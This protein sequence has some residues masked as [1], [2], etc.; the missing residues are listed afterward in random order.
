MRVGPHVE[1]GVTESHTGWVLP[2]APE[3]P[4]SGAGIRYTSGTHSPAR[5]KSEFYTR[6]T[7]GPMRPRHLSKLRIAVPS[8]VWHCP[9]F[10]WPSWKPRRL[11]AA[12][13]V[14]CLIHDHV[15]LIYLLALSGAHPFFSIP[16]AMLAWTIT[17]VSAFPVYSP[18]S[19]RR[20]SVG[21]ATPY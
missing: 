14:P 12:P 1:R 4:A 18:A 15:P 16:A 10:V 3:V 21:H 6:W 13:T 7:G 11:S 17:I 5:Q 9:P 19:A 20:R 2:R 8:E